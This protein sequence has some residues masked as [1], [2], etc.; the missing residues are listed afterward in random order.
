MAIPIRNST[1]IQT[2]NPIIMK[3]IIKVIPL[4]IFGC[5][6]AGLVNAQVPIKTKITPKDPSKEVLDAVRQLPTTTAANWVEIYQERNFGGKVAR[7]SGSIDDFSYPLV[8]T[9]KESVS[10]K[11]APGYI[12]F[13]SFNQ[14]FNEE[15]AFMGNYAD[16]GKKTKNAIKSIRVEKATKIDVNLSGF[17]TQIHN[18]DCKRIFGTVKLQVFEK[19][20]SGAWVACPN[21]DFQG[22]A[23]TNSAML[24]FPN[25]GSSIRMIYQKVDLYN[26][27]NSDF[28]KP[29]LF[30]VSAINYNGRTIPA[31]NKTAFSSNPLPIS[32]GYMVSQK[33]LDENRIIVRV[34][35]DLG[36]HHKQSDTA[37]DYSSS[38]KMLTPQNFDIYYKNAPSYFT[39]GPYE[40][41]GNPNSNYGMASGKR[42]SINKTLV[43]H[44]NKVT[45]VPM[46]P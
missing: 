30:N 34:T 1:I 17:S 3:K 43:V 44:M 12:A 15:A 9:D 41:H 35:T 13:I 19:T 4:F 5:C 37:T 24:G 25:T 11:V 28:S 18:N 16:F 7:Y 38:V 6:M 10:L 23:L 33:A 29:H 45:P 46:R 22:S 27:A 21:V 42:Y 14:E 31:I 2:I 40:I 32:R 36:A 39:V 8:F 20:S 26:R